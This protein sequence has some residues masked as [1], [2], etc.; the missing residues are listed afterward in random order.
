[1]QRLPGPDPLGTAQLHGTA[2][3]SIGPFRALID[4]EETMHM[5][6]STKDEIAGTVEEVKGAVKE[7]AGHVVGN[8]RLE[9]E[10]R[11]QNVAGKV[12]K[13]V[14]QIEKVFEK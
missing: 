3:A 6:P 13:K 5:K 1:M 12:Q 11:S 8:A 2:S 14:G 7:K 10:G 9:A 4:P